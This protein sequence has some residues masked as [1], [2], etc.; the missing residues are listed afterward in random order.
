[1]EEDRTIIKAGPVLNYRSEIHEFIRGLET[2]MKAVVEAGYSTYVVDIL[3]ELAVE[4][5]MAHPPGS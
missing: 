3:E 2:E 5:K 4:V 1:M